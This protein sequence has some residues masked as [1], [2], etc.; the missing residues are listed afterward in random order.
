MA[1]N[2]NDWRS[3]IDFQKLV[4][5]LVERAEAKGLEDEKPDT[6]VEGIRFITKTVTANVEMLGMTARLALSTEKRVRRLER[7][8]FAM[9]CVLLFFMG[10]L[11]T[12][13]VQR[14]VG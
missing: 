9:G 10:M 11:G 13:I 4:E 12:A 8:V 14:I 7:W 5:E 3:E 2:S 1:G 6:L